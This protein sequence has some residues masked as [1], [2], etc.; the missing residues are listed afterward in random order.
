MTMVSRDEPPGGAESGGTGDFEAFYR[1][2]VVVLTA[3][4]TA[5]TGSRDLGAD[6]AHDALLRAYRAWPVVGG[7]ERPGAW[8]RRVTLNLVADSRRRARRE[9]RAVARLAGRADARAER[10]DG[11]VTDE[12][13][14]QAVRALPE[15]QR[16]TVA[17]YYVDDLP[18]AEIATVLEVTTGTVKAALHAARAALA[19]ALGVEEGTDADDR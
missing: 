17:L 9:Q 10:R 6:L 13:F 12:Q 15:R 4:A 14:W 2:E 18:V 8:V 1:R 5:L 19:A 16:A 7:Y 3:L 11:E